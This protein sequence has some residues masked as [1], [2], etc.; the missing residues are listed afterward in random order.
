[1]SSEGPLAHLREHRD[2]I[3]RDLALLTGVVSRG[4]RV[5]DVGAGRGAFVSEAC[6]AGLRA[7]ALD[8]QV[9]AVSVWGAS[10][11]PGVVASGA[12]A[13]FAD[14]TFEAVRMKEV[15]EH[16]ADPLALVREAR[17]L[18][19]PGGFLVTHTPTPYSQFYPIG[20]F[21]DDYT[22][23]RP[24]SRLGLSRLFADAGMSVESIQGYVSGRT[25]VER[26]VGRALALVAPH[27]Y[28]VVA[29]RPA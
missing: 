15:L 24:F 6:A 3:E 7:C 1:M 22:H 4:G 9:E 29:K 19:R 17:R 27:I 23:V 8:T 25:A 14:A 12:H 13:P 10:R 11:L 5:L 20:N 26:T 16:V 2:V 18:L 28:R 21:W